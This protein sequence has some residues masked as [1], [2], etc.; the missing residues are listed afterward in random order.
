[1]FHNLLSFYKIHYFLSLRKL[2]K[3]TFKQEFP[4]C[5]IIS[6]CITM[7]FRCYVSILGFELHLHVDIVNNL[8]K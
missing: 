8:R 1:M 4:E 5:S 6:V 2:G 7:A 3:N